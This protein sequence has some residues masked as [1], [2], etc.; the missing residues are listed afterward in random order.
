VWAGRP[1]DDCVSTRAGWAAKAATAALASGR[2]GFGGQAECRSK[3]QRF[4]CCR[5]LQTKERRR[6][7][8][9]W[10][11]AVQVRADTRK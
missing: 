2:Q 10:L 11:S 5:S 9:T 8:G 6:E 1:V 3:H 4:Y 7:A